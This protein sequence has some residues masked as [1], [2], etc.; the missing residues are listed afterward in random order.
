M[1]NRT[2]NRGV[3]LILVIKGTFLLPVILVIAMISCTKSGTD[4]D[5]GVIEPPTLT[6]TATTIVTQ[7]TAQSGGYVTSD[8]SAPVTARGICWGINP[9]PTTTN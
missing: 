8:A 3:S 1:N 9:G 5:P 4:K 6:T 7:Y 2:P